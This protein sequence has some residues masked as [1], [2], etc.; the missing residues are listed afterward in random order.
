MFEVFS[1]MQVSRSDC[2]EID[3]VRHNSGERVAVVFGPG[4]T[5]GLRQRTDSLI[6]CVGLGKNTRRQAEDR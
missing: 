2:D 5:K 4:S 3:V 1:S 6:V